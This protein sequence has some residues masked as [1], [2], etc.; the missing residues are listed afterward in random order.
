M[1][2][3]VPKTSRPRGTP[4][5]EYRVGK[6]DYVI[7][8]AWTMPFAGLD[9]P[10]RRRPMFIGEVRMHEDDDPVMRALMWRD[11]GADGVCLRVQP[12]DGD[13]VSAIATSTAMPVMVEGPGAAVEEASARVCD[14]IMVLMPCDDC[15]VD[16]R[17]HLLTGVHVDAFP[18]TV[19]GGGLK[20]A[21]E[22]G[23]RLRS[24]A[25]SSETPG[26]PTICDVTSVWDMSH[27]IDE[28]GM[29]RMTMLESQAALAAILA[30]ADMIVMRD[31]AALDSAIGY[32]EELADL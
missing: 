24:E 27:D 6:G 32:G 4:L 21:M 14:S 8:G 30:G 19:L 26:R 5:R 25:L 17:D 29:A 16:A 10:L 13:T 9:S 2:M 28:A 3:F 11:L 22:E 20:N 15:E 31:P 23:L 18:P 12:G 7:G 1:R